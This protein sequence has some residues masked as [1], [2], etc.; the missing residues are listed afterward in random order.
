MNQ[1]TDLKDMAQ[2]LAQQVEKDFKGMEVWQTLVRMATKVVNEAAE[3]EELRMPLERECVEALA[4]VAMPVAARPP[5]LDFVAS[6][7]GVVH[8]V[9]FG[10][11]A[12][13]MALATMTCG[14]R[15]GGAVGAKLLP[16]SELPQHVPSKSAFAESAKE[17]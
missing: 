11:P 4:V 14:W 13:E 15:F 10:P 8:K 3:K 16:E 9:A 17:A 5:S 12:E 2:S 7:C 1:Q 6:S